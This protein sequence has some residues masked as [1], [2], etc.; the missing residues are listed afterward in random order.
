[1][2]DEPVRCKRCNN[3]DQIRKVSSVVGEGTASRPSEY[4]TSGAVPSRYPDVVSRTGL[5]ER[6]RM[7]SPPR[8]TTSPGAESVFGCGVA[9]VLTIIFGIV[10]AIGHIAHLVDIMA[11][12]FFFGW[13]G[14]AIFVANRHVNE[15]KRVAAIASRWPGMKQVWDDL[16]YCY[17][18]DAVFR[19]SNPSRS[20]SADDMADLLLAESS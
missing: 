9:I 6:L 15:K 5:A 12:L 7:P 20:A 3:N 8:P 14:W 1:M 11:A 4:W 17:R 13:V 2:G 16:Y 10:S 19:G 18:D